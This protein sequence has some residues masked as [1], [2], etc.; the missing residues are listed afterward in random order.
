MHSHN[1]FSINPNSMK[2]SQQV[3]SLDQAK[4]LQELGILQDAMWF[5]VYYSN[6][7]SF[8]L[9]LKKS[10]DG[11]YDYSLKK[12]GDD[13]VMHLCA[14]FTISELAMSLQVETG[15]L[16]PVMLADQ[17]I[18]EIESGAQSIDTINLRFFSEDIVSLFA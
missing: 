12:Y 17:L 11:L 8:S 6:S 1:S 18:A 16:N 2:I 10:A 9:N 5:Y 13:C 15:S 4:R 3:C 7:N 14:A